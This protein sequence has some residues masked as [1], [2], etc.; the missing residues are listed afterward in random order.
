MGVLLKLQQTS[1]VEEQG[2]IMLAIGE[3]ETASLYL[4]ES[5]IVGS[6]SNAFLAASPNVI[7]TINVLKGSFGTI[8]PESV[9][10][11][12]GSVYWYDAKNGRVIQYSSNGLFPISDYKMTRFW[13]LFSK[14]YM[15]MTGDEIEVLGNRPYIFT[16]V[17]PHHNL[18]FISVPKLLNTPPKGYLPDYPS[19]I[20][21]F[22]IWDGTGKTLVYDLK[23]EPNRWLGAV[24]FV[25][26]TFITLND[27]LFSVKN[28]Q[29]YIH[30]QINYN[31]IYG[32]ELKP[33]LMIVSNK[34]ASKIKS[35]NSV[36]VESN[37]RP[38][39]VYL[40]ND[41]PYQQSSDLVD[42]DF[43][44]FEGVFKASFYRNK[45]VPT[46]TGYSTS[47]LMTKEKMRGVAMKMMF[48]FTV[49]NKPLELKFINIGYTI[50]SGNKNM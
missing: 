38:T 39:F 5:Q 13:S 24:R 50:S 41:Y 43:R 1:K 30:N 27:E 18:L 17:D 4:G 10:E 14:Q 16:T 36:S 9:V 22:D 42:F 26:E 28:G 46:A 29:L 11:Y 34:D 15:S 6:D 20:Y 35:Y 2:N 21:P 31:N 45:L 44:E 32:E 7:G 12:R 40:Y 23:P 49:L 3:N 33:R 19:R 48:E 37:M 47:G 25:S 8:N